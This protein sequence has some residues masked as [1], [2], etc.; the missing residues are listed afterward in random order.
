MIF[1]INAIALIVFLLFGLFVFKSRRYGAY[2][3]FL[4]I[5]QLWAIVSCFYI[6]TGIFITEQNVFSFPTGATYRLV[7]YN[8]VFFA[9]AVLTSQVF[10][11]P[12]VKQIA[13]VSEKK[14]RLSNLW[15]IPIY[16]VALAMFFNAFLTF[17][18]HSGS[19][20]RF[21]FWQYAIFPKIGALYNFYYI[22]I[23]MTG[24]LF[25]MNKGNKKIRTLS[26]FAFLLF[27]GSMIFIG[28]KFSP[29]YMGT[30][31]FIIP[32]LSESANFLYKYKGKVVKW[33][34]VLMI[35]VIALSVRE[36]NN[37]VGSENAFDLLINRVLGLQGHLAWGTDLLVQMGN[38]NYS[39]NF[40][41]EVN[42]IIHPTVDHENAGMKSLMVKVSGS[43]GEAFIRHGINFTMGFPAIVP[44]MTGTWKS[45]F[46]LSFFG[47]VLGVL[48]TSLNF[49]VRRNEL[50]P[51][52]ILSSIYI[53]SLS[54]FTMGNFY[55]LFNGMNLFLIFS[56]I[57]YLPI[58]FYSRKKAFMLNRF[59]VNF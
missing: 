2:L 1:T 44:F 29:I 16:L 58:Y 28:H 18:L 23:F 14:K 35:V 47:V 55:V 9:A 37:T 36:Y 20:D 12:D 39:N 38:L 48:I 6:E 5:G 41:D 24:F 45:V 8:M 46:L 42:E 17:I 10:S 57:C 34:F 59:K 15:L 53:D 22:L 19:Y 49:W 54:A 52:A 32:M 11:R 27:N 30:L 3:L 25:R 51:S 56:M 31:I 40:A 7:L 13:P 26:L 33:V 21:T 43:I 50:I 4:Y